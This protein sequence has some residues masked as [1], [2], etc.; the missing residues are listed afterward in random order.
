MN[1][2]LNGLPDEMS[3]QV[4]DNIIAQGEWKN[5]DDRDYFDDLDFLIGAFDWTASFEGLDYWADYVEFAGDLDEL[6]EECL[7]DE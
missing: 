2:V 5:M 7:G 6:L 3:E 1:E 4:I